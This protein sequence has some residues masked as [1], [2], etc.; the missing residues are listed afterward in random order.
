[1]NTANYA[2]GSGELLNSRNICDNMGNHGGG[3]LI[4]PKFGMQ[5]APIPEEMKPVYASK[6]T[7]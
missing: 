4:F 5:F 3:Y 1:M 6:A 7:E 2:T